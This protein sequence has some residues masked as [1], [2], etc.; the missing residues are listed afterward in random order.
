MDSRGLI[1]TPP[2][3]P[4]RSPT[5]SPAMSPTRSPTIIGITG[6][7]FHGKD[8]LSDYLVQN[9]GYI[10]LS[11]AQPVK[12]IAKIVFGF[13]E[14]Q[15]HGDLKE[16]IDERWNITPR[17]CFQ[18]IGTELFRDNIGKILPHVRENIWAYCLVEKIK[19]QLKINPEKKFVISDLRFP[20]E[21]DA[22]KSLEDSSNIQCKIIRIH[23]P[24]VPINDS[25]KHISEELIDQLIVD[26]EIINDSDMKSLFD[27]LYLLLK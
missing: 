12:D 2:M 4:T 21:I 16:T 23:R 11:F 5:R 19:S 3:S 13:N 27:K 14:E 20:N 10:K 26:H 18:F 6:R 24:N 15:L 7:K 9:H 8:T 17:E 1:G 22:L 25:C